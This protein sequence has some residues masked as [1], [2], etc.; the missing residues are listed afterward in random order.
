VGMLLGWRIGWVRVNG[1]RVSRRTGFDGG[2]SMT[3]PARP[4]LCHRS[5]VRL[6]GGIAEAISTDRSEE[7]IRRASEHDERMLWTADLAR[8]HLSTREKDRR[9]RQG[10]VLARSLIEGNRD[11]FL[12]LAHAISRHPVTGAQ[13]RRIVAEQAG[14][15]PG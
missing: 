15:R 7:V 11:A 3:P 1:E 5:A 9:V 8:S 10:S 13:A 2:A 14:G 12:D 4:S 6:A